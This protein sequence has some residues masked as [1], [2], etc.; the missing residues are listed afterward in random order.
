MPRTFRCGS[1]PSARNEHVGKAR[2][3]GNTLANGGG[4]GPPTQPIPV[5]K[6]ISKQ[7]SPDDAYFI[8]EAVP[9]DPSPV[10]TTASIAPTAII[11]ARE[12]RS[13]LCNVHR[14]A[15]LVLAKTS[16]AIAPTRI[17]APAADDTSLSSEALYRYA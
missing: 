6:S 10:N 11:G 3:S 14:T 17:P 15:N 7:H 4:T 12:P 5:A 9:T 16:S 8:R 13:T 1:K 2:S